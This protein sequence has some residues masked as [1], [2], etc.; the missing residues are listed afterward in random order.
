MSAGPRRGWRGFRARYGVAVRR[1]LGVDLHP[2]VVPLDDGKKLDAHAC[3]G[4]AVHGHGLC[5]IWTTFGAVGSGN[6][7]PTRSISGRPSCVSMNGRNTASNERMPHSTAVIPFADAMK[8]MLSQPKRRR[9]LVISF[10]DVASLFSR[11][12]IALA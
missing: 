3:D 9:I 5:G 6:N 7:S 10:R 12:D 8:P 4:F 2:L 1:I 11:S